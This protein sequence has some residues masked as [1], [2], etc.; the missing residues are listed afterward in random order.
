M[1]RPPFRRWVYVGA[2]VAAI[3]LLILI[4]IYYAEERRARRWSGEG[5]LGSVRYYEN[6][7]KHDPGN[8]NAMKMLASL[9]YDLR[10]L[11]ESR[12]YYGK[13][14]EA[15]PDDPESYYSIAVIDWTKAYQLRRQ[16]KYTSDGEGGSLRDPKACAELRTR[17]ETGIR[18][19][20]EMLEHVFE[21]SPDYKSATFYMG[22][23]FHEKA[24][25]ECGNPTA[26][27]DDL[28]K[29]EQ[30]MNRKK[31]EPS[32]DD[33]KRARLYRASL[34]TPSSS[35]GSGKS[36]ERRICRQR[37]ACRWRRP[38]QICQTRVA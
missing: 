35:A 36:G 8:V 6:I 15:D 23:L 13:A 17:N 31:P 33:S 18:E 19:G 5:S 27:R 38:Q 10:K 22:M 26:I 16:A 21:L 28:K 4:G 25:I 1:G 2:Q 7:L 32:Y 30:W 9:Y 12:Q 29:A 20:M 14:V 37:P 11:D 3:A 24:Y 34:V